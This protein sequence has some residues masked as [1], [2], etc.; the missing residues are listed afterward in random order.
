VKLPYNRRTDRL[1]NAIAK[2][3]PEANVALEWDEKKEKK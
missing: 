1:S 3:D 2:L